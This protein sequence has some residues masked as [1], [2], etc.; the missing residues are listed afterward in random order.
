M[1]PSMPEPNPIVPAAG[2]LLLQVPPAGVPVSVI[3]DPSHTCSGVPLI[4]VG[5]ALTNTTIVR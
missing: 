5:L 3:V 2:V 4:A 1:P